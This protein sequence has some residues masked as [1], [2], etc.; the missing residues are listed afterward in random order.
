MCYCSE[1]KAKDNTNKI[2]M[3]NGLDLRP[4][5]I[6]ERCGFKHMMN[7]IKPGYSVPSRKHI[8]TLLKHKHSLFIEKLK[9]KIDKGAESIMLTTDIWICAATEAYIAV[10]VHYFHIDWKTQY[11]VL[12]ISAFPEC[13]TGIE[14]ATKLKEI[15]DNFRAS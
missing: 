13:H 4:V 1:G 11:F 7:Y 15:Y 6:V 12:K 8:C 2:V 14:I 3:M 10:T 9:E 5:R